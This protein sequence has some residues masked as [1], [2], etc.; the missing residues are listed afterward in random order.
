MEAARAT[1]QLIAE[2]VGPFVRITVQDA[3]VELHG[4]DT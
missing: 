3:L 2:E 4:A 1:E